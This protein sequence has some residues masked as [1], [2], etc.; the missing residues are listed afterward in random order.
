MFDTGKDGPWAAPGR[1]TLGGEAGSGDSEATLG[2]TC[3]L[4]QGDQ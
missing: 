3:R 4:L 2:L 1:E